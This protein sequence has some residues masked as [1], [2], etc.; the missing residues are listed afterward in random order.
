MLFPLTTRIK[1]DPGSNAIAPTLQS[2]TSTITQ[3]HSPQPTFPASFLSAFDEPWRIKGCGITPTILYT[4]DVKNASAPG[5]QLLAQSINSAVVSASCEG[6]ITPGKHHFLPQSRCLVGGDDWSTGCWAVPLPHD[7]FS[8]PAP[9]SAQSW[10]CSWARPGH[11]SATQDPQPG[12]TAI[13]DS[14]GFKPGVSGEPGP[15]MTELV[16]RVIITKCQPCS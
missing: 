9:S 10:C 8:Q 11:S 12:E 14:P 4:S 2:I 16:M 15:H 6:R 1:R 7:G 5:T 13:S 3:P